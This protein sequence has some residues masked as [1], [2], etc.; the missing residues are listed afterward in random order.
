[1]NWSVSFLC[2][3]G[4]GIDFDYY[5]VEWLALETNQD[6]SVILEVAPKYCILDSF[7]DYEGHSISS[8]GSLP[9]V[10][11]L[12]SSELNSLIPVHFSSL[13]PKMSVFT[14]AIS[15]H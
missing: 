12:M 14:L 3:R 11:D 9:T 2:I 15:C 5:N 4:K 7:I 13:I 6:V 8:M 1:M 10:V